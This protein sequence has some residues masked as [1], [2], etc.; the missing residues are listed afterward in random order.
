MKSIVYASIAAIFWSSAAIADPFVVN[1]NQ[2]PST[3]D[4]A[5]ACDIIGNGYVAPLY[6][7]LVAYERK[8]YPGPEGVTVTGEDDS[9]I[10]PALA[11]SWTIS[12]DGLTYTFQIR[13][14]T[15]FA[16]GNALDAPAVAASLNR[17]L[18]SGACGTYYMEAGA[19]GN[20]QGITADGNT[21]TITLANPQPLL[22]HALTQPNLS[23][24]DVAVAEANGGNDWMANNAAGS[25]PYTLAEYQPGVRAVYKANP[26]YFGA[27]PYEDE[28]VVNFIADPSALLLQARNGAADVTLGL[29]KQMVNQ[30]RSELNVVEVPSPRF[31]IVSLPNK[32]APFDNVLFRRALSYAVPYEAIEQSVAFGYADRF[33]GPFPPEFSAYTEDNGAPRAFNMEKAI[34]LLTESGVT[35]SVPLEMT[36]IEGN[37]EQEQIATILQGA[38]RALGVEATIGKLSASAYVETISSPEKK[39]AIVRFDGPSIADPA[40]LLSYDMFCQSPFNQSNYCN[41]DAETIYGEALAISNIDGRQGKWDAIAKIWVE[42]VPRIPIYADVFTA[43]LDKDVTR[44]DFAQDGPFDLQ[45]WGR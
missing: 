43:V 19:F 37:A 34:A 5:F 3:L 30:V 18:S 9:K 10:A 6:A 13:T 45:N 11:Q 25:G 16:S 31:M 36:I 4:P 15:K 12:D 35:G 14:G 41:T 33:F 20:T 22:I 24:V 38:W 42:D 17:A 2:P 8:N 26:N 39:S 29:P 21:V 32:I 40:W 27:A 28:V 1:V 44:W 23:I 7:P